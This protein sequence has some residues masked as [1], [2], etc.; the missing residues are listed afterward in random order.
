[1]CY[2]L[3]FTWTIDMP[4]NLLTWIP[5]GMKHEAQMMTMDVGNKSEIEGIN[6]PSS[7]YLIKVWGWFSPS[8]IY[9]PIPIFWKLSIVRIVLFFPWS[10]CMFGERTYYSF[11]SMFIV[12]QG[13]TAY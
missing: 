12:A 5:R 11:V 8:A 7:G 3:T 4:H 1:M 2:L 6:F 10:W 13:E 9:K